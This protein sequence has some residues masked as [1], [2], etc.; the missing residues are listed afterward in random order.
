MPFEARHRVTL[1][2]NRYKPPSLFSHRNWLD[3]YRGSLW[4]PWER[5]HLD[6]TPN[7]YSSVTPIYV[8][9]RELL[10]HVFATLDIRFESDRGFMEAS[11]EAVAN[12]YGVELSAYMFNGKSLDDY[13][14]DHI[15]R[16]KV[17]SYYEL[18]RI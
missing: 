5:E 7:L 4:R 8:R 1:C 3:V 17:I 14:K 9:C 15:G 10:Q 2:L 13:Y 16:H 12:H 6:F 11:G 18:H